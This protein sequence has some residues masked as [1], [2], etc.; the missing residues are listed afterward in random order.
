MRSLSPGKAPG[1]ALRNRPKNRLD[2]KL[3]I[4]TAWHTY[5]PLSCQM[6]GLFMYG[7]ALEGG[8]ARGAA[9]VGVLR[10][11][12]EHH[13]LPGSIA[14]SS[15]GAMVS[16]AYAWRGRVADAQEAMAQCARMQRHLLDA[17]L[18]GIARGL[19]ELA[20]F[21]NFRL[22][23]VFK[24]NRL[25]RWMHEFTG[26]ALMSEAAL[27]LVI[28]A[29]DLISGRA[30]YFASCPAPERG[31]QERLVGAAQRGQGL[32]EAPYS[33][34]RN[35]CGPTGGP[36]LWELGARIDVAVRASTA[37]P[38]AFAPLD[39][40]TYQLVDGGLLEN[41]PV[42]ALHALGTSHVLGVAL[43]SPGSCDPPDDVLGIGLRSI[44]VMQAR[45][46]DE[47][48]AGARLVLR[49]RL[50]A[51]GGLFDFSR[52][53][54]YERIGYETALEA[55]PRIRRVLGP[56]ASLSMGD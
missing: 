36:P 30:V 9:H 46:G 40:G 34:Q 20:T 53:A 52:M 35:A 7:L 56:S 44:H 4:P 14:G 41:L 5:S 28:P 12:E 26:G 43:E 18:W 8:G 10:A 50:P 21:S 32:K 22:E 24:G 55:M 27:P 33:A 25:Q 45:L 42:H 31:A 13:L 6:G 38:V 37:I 11:L 39:Y 19:W 2:R 3:I 1:K 23:G 15:S 16:A 49:V 54:E 47:Q 51:E 29:V 17:N 48:E